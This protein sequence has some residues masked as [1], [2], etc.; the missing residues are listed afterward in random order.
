MTLATTAGLFV[1]TAVMEILG[2]FPPC[3]WLRGKAGPWVLPPA[4]LALL[5]MGII[6][7]G[8]ASPRT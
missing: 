8:A 7:W 3:L 4:A 6:M 2:C 1:V 5:G